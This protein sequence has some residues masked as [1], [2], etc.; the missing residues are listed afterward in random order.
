[1]TVR[2]L[3]L[4]GLIPLTLG[5]CASHT[6]NLIQDGS[7]QDITVGTFRHEGPEGTAMFLEL[8]G[9]RFEAQGF[10]I[11]RKQNLAE[12]RRL[13]S[14]GKHYDRIFSGL[15]NDHY[16]YSAQPVLRAD[17]GATLRCSAVWRSGGSPSGHCLAADDSRIN[18]R[19]G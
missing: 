13:Y 2:I 10:A 15:D 1:M 4:A 17:S 18:F 3:V 14:T 5:G 11:E 19:F 7:D 16:V 6:H 12:L 9:V 8:R